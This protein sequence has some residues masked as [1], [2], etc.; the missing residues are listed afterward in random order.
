MLWFLLWLTVS[1]YITHNAIH[2]PADSG[3]SGIEPLA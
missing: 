2:L 3:A 1:Y